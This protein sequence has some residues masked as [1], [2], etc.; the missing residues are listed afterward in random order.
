MIGAIILA[1][2]ASSRI[3]SDKALL[4]YHGVPFL[5]QIRGVVQAAGLHPSLVVLGPS[6]ANVL[7]E[8]D[9]P[10]SIIVRNPEPDT[11]PLQSLKLALGGLNQMVDGVLVWHVDRPRIELLTVEHLLAVART[12]PEPIIVPS[13][14]G[15][16]GH[17]VIFMRPVF[18]EILRTPNALGARAVVRA[19]PS[20]VA[21]VSVDDPS[22]LE[23]VDTPEDYKA[24]G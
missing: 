12:G 9:L 20:R 16:R 23:D 18:D 8:L 21:V 3:G 13:Y 4:K 6:A 19:D 11:G 17:P 14:E 10:A 24:L 15:R 5:I 1:A 7:D 2:G 22:V